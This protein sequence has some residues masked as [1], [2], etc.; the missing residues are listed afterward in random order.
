MASVYLMEIDLAGDFGGIISEVFSSG[1]AAKSY[2]RE[3]AKDMGVGLQTGVEADAPYAD[4]V[5]SNG[6]LIHITKKELKGA[7]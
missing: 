4:F 6:H 7:L 3:W 1:P 2:V 5:T